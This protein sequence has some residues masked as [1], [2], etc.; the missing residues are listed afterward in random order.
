MNRFERGFSLLP[1]RLATLKRPVLGRRFFAGTVF[2]RR[3]VKVLESL[4]GSFDIR[5][6]RT[7][8]A[9]DKAAAH[10]FRCLLDKMVTVNYRSHLNRVV[11]AR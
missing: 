6:V 8:L 1:T 11:E 7:R 5:S 4:S 3:I 2:V 10:S 9:V